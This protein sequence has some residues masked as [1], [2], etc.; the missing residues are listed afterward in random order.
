MYSMYLESCDENEK[1]SIDTHR[2]VFKEMNRSIHRPKKDL[3]SL[4]ITYNE[5]DSEK[6][7]KLEERYKVHI[8]EKKK[9]RQIKQNCKYQA[10]AD[11]S[12]LSAVFDLQQVIHLPKSNDSGVFYKKRLAGFNFTVC[13][14]DAKDCF[15]Y[16]WSEID[17]RKG[18]CEI[19]TCVYK[20][21]QHYGDN[22][23][24]TAHL[25]SDGCAGY[26]KNSIVAANLLYFVTN[27][28]NVQQVSLKFF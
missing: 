8:E 24:Q 1:S 6:K 9:V 11:G 25:F 7:F 20:F 17:S 3:R 18:S 4:C 28:K 13:N 27:S 16:T 19:A 26:N 15:C 5:G 14:L 21:L 10:I 22:R 23:A 12:T 2:C